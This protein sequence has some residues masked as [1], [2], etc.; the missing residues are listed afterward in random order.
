MVAS[1]HPD[2]SCITLGF[3]T[4]CKLESVFVPIWHYCHTLA[5]YKQ[6][7][8]VRPKLH[9]HRCLRSAPIQPCWLAEDGTNFTCACVPQA[10]RASVCLSRNFRKRIV[11]DCIQKIQK[12]TTCRSNQANLVTTNIMRLS[13]GVPSTFQT[14]IGCQLFPANTIG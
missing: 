1:T 12:K 6:T 4:P 2:A 13:S 3:S 11:L 14:R 5:S 7:E 10:S 9:Q 8:T